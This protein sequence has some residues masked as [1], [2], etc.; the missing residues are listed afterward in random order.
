MDEKE[1]SIVAG[2]ERAGM[3]LDNVPLTIEYQGSLDVK[4]LRLA[5]EHLA[6]RHP[7]F[8]AKVKKDNGRYLLYVPDGHYPK[9]RIVNVETISLPKLLDEIAE[10]RRKGLLIDECARFILL[11]G[12]SKGYIITGMSHVFMDIGSVS[13]YYSELWDIY[14]NIVSGKKITSDPGELPEPPSSTWSSLPLQPT[15]HAPES[16]NPSNERAATQSRTPEYQPPNFP[17]EHRRKLH[18]TE[19]ETS[20]ILQFCRTHHIRIGDLL[21][22]AMLSLVRKIDPDN[23]PTTLRLSTIVDARR[24]SIKKIEATGTGF[25]ADQRLTTLNVD[26]E[27]DFLNVAQKVSVYLGKA[28]NE[29]PSSDHIDPLGLHPRFV[30]CDLFLNNGG[31]ACQK[32]T[33]PKELQLVDFDLASE[34]TKSEGENVGVTI[35]YKTRIR[36]W[37][38]NKRMKIYCSVRGDLDASLLDAFEAKVRSCTTNA[39]STNIQ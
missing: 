1:S 31:V 28:R 33:T 4:S 32:L 16:R 21:A 15:S 35:G 10:E 24:N 38:F 20:E 11:H 6:T 7:L 19:R 26:L 29:R 2:F 13:V 17:R 27:D 12:D 5:L 22:G 37:T 18:F 34:F 36:T 23:C 9:L 3:L 30:D 8:R 14:T 25:V 39:V